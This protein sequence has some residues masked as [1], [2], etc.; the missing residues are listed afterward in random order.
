MGQDSKNK[1]IIGTLAPVIPRSVPP[2]SVPPGSVPPAGVQQPSVPPGSMPPGSVPPASHQQP[3]IMTPGMTPGMAPSYPGYPGGPGAPLPGV[4]DP[5]LLVGQELCGYTIKRKLAEGGMGVVFEG[6]HGK[7]G[8]RGAIKLLKLEFCR[9]EEVIERFRQEARAVN[10]IRHENIVDIYDFGRDQHGRV[11]FVM[12]YLEG[13]PLS[14]RIRRGA[15]P[16]QEAFPVLDQTLRALHAAHDK[17][18]VHRDLKPDNIW[19]KYVDGQIQVKLLDFGIAKLV[20]SESPRE[21]LTQ[22]GSVIGTPHYMSPEQIN[23]SRDVDHRTD[24]YA[25]GVITYEMFTGV[26]PFV[27]DTLQAIMTGHLFKEPPRLAQIP[28]NLGV[29]AP[30]AEIVE[31]MLVKDASARYDSVADVLS[32]LYAVYQHQPPARAQTLSRER[33]TRTSMQVP[34]MVAA[35][36]AP[37]R[38]KGKRAAVIGGVIAAGLAVGGVAIWQSQQGSEPAAMAT[39]ETATTTTEQTTPTQPPAEPP[40]NPDEA[41]KDA[42]TTLRA[43]LRETE[44]TVRV[45]GA[46]ALGKIKDQ[47]SVPVLTELAEQDVDDQ[48]RGHAGEALGAIGV[49][50]AAPLLQKLEAAAPPP[51]K[52]LYA[53]A[54]AR[55]GDQRARD[56]LHGYARSRDLAVAF[57]AGLKLAD[58]S[59]PGD[60]RA[61]GALQGLA[62]QEAKLRELTQD[63]YVAV[64]L[65]TK[66]AALRHAPA[67]KELY[68]LLER[69][70]PGARL[71]AAKGLA[72]LGDDAGKKI[73]EEV[74]ASEGSKDRLDAALALIP[75]GEYA[76]F[77]LITEQLAAREP[78]IR[79]LAARGLGEIGERKS[80]K[81]LIALAGDKDWT[82][83]VAASAAILSIVGL[84]PQVLAQASVDWTKNA[85]ASENWAERQAAAGVLGDLKEEEA[86]P[87]LGKAIEDKDPR[88]RLAAAANAGKL[89]GRQ[90]AETVAR[91]V[92]AEQ[93]PKVKEQQVKALGQ[94]GSPVAKDTLAQIAQDPGRLG[95]FAAGSLIAVGDTSAKARLDAAVAAPQ[96]ELRLAA[97]EAA[98]AAKNPIVVP[99]LKTG[100]TDRV[101]DVR[102]AAAEGLAGFKAE[103]DAAK[104]VL[105]E[106][107]KRKDLLP[108]A[109]AA[110][111]KFDEQVSTK[112]QTPAQMLESTDP[113]QRLAAVPIVRAM[114][115]KDGVPLL[116]RLVAD[117]DREVRRAGVDAIEGVAEKDK[118]EAIKLY[119]P[120]ARDADAVV[121]AKAQS[122][123][124]ELVPPRPPPPP[125]P[126]VVKQ[127]EPSAPP[128]PPPTPVD[129]TLPEVRKLA[130]QVTEAIAEVK[131]TTQVIE[132]LAGELATTIAG[133]TKPDPATSKRVDELVK[134]IGE[135]AAKLEAAA[136]K[137]E[138]AAKAAAKAAT[139]AAGTSPSAD[140]RKL[141]EDASAR[142]VTAR[143]AAAA[144]RSKAEDAAEQ[145]KKFKAQWAADPKALIQVANVAIAGGN[146]SSAKRDLDEAAKLLRERGET[147]ADLQYSYGRLYDRQ[148]AQTKDPAA[149]RK[150]LQQA[151]NAYRA[152]AKTGKGP[153]VQQASGRA[154]ELEVKLKR[155]GP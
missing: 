133:T 135:A 62:A 29:P 76:G 72:R 113:K 114:P 8:R 54:L 2:G 142:A 71:A 115:P 12:E 59:Q 30:I 31:R 75:L 88:V 154:E 110:L 137:A 96:T 79:R 123:L 81:A 139:G 43:S 86:V 7:I 28:A 122:K 26:T 20:G 83:R 9:S 102:F 74:L 50:E 109:M 106:A 47:P 116:R 108:R 34:G 101:L 107:L 58:V 124:A 73:L 155:L 17:G 95:V 125:P 150:L 36:A 68:A 57:G 41:R 126:P 25:M 67:R 145:A 89:K 128:P 66:L 153:N 51:L 134:N 103:K 99:T 24:I 140:A 44:P 94:I 141:V 70:H 11:F 32:D 118:D 38:G 82:L 97:V 77:D 119:K 42:E 127:P 52:V 6:E 13:E 91:A 129:L 37:P 136:A 138:T 35:P 65:M 152:F 147:N 117:P 22:T 112:V 84:D 104:P 92:T 19:L 27:G 87:L 49:T 60:P 39:T 21:K 85:L 5:D 55:L 120:L 4:G 18:F 132:Q 148:A 33:P 105:E 56:R 46:D 121:R 23:G 14:A 40:I 151:V 53:S 61:I 48:V 146:F 111:L 69:D 10:A 130:D 63:P 15:L 80:L 64:L 149:Q 131:P 98:S 16:W 100:V 45:Q 3:T 90:A 143:D 78:D 93:D 144:A 1:T